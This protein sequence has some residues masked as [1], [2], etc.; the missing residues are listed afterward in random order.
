MP[1]EALVEITDFIYFVRR[2]MLQPE[3]FEEERHDLLLRSELKRL[4]R[5]EDA[6]LEREFEGY[7]QLFPRE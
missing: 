6:H 2:R 3:A 7:E 1:P 4:S 5:D